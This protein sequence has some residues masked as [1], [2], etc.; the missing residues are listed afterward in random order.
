[1]D[2]LG[3]NDSMSNSVP[4]YKEHNSSVVGALK[5]LQNLKWNEEEK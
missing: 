4:Q 1:V 3:L 2:L 5:A